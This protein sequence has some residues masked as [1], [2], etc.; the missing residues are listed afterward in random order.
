M[1]I[2]DKK[3]EKKSKVK[4]NV[5]CSSCARAMRGRYKVQKIS[6]NMDFTCAMG[7]GASVL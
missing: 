5:V 7:T 1:T 4:K 6:G 3:G 2:D